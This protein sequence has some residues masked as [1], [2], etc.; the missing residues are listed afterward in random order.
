MPQKGEERINHPGSQN[1][2][3]R[4]PNFAKLIHMLQQLPHFPPTLL[5]QE[6]NIADRKTCRCLMRPCCGRVLKWEHAQEYGCN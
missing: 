2:T 1:Q 4:T 5:R 6:I 3:T